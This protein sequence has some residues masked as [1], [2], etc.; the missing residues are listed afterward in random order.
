MKIQRLGKCKIPG[1]ITLRS[2]I[3]EQ[4][5][6]AS[7]SSRY[8]ETEEDVGEASAFYLLPDHGFNLVVYHQLVEKTNVLGRLCGVLSEDF[9]VLETSCLKKLV[10]VWEWESKIHVLRKHAGLEMLHV[11]AFEEDD[12]EEEED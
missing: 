9:M 6:Q 3:S 7:R 8:F 2:R 4:P 5:G 12:I 11:E 1:D 10:G